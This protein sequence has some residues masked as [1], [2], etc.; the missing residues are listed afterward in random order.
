MKKTYDETQLRQ[1]IVSNFS[2]AG[3]LRQLGLKPAGGNYKTINREISD[4][5]LDI[6]HFTGQ[7]WSVGR[8][9][10]PKPARSLEE[11]LVKNSPQRSSSH[12]RRRLIKEGIFKPLCN[13]CG[14]E[15]WLDKSIPLEL[16]HIN[17]DSGDNRINNLCLLCPNCHAFTPTY[18]GRNIGKFNPSPHGETT[19]TESL[20]LSAER[21][22]GLNPA[23]GTNNCLDCNHIISSRGTRCKS[24]RGKLQEEKI[25]WPP[26]DLLVE[27]L[28]KGGN[29]CQIAKRLGVSDNAIRKYI[30]R[31]GLTLPSR[32]KSI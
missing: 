16:E 1:A 5:N 31:N 7:G 13:S 6:S 2:V 28:L 32:R 3:V 21:C 26:V 19:D 14:L 17:G 24:C 20:S 18:R 15:E 22:A 23:G 10:P 11:I 27:E 8:I 4:L 30:L 25:I 12:L 9:E 29:Y